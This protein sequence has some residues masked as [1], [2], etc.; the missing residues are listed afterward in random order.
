MRKLFALLNPRERRSF[1]VLVVIMACEAL[2]EMAGIA[3]IP[4]YIT[5]LAFPAGLASQSW[6]SEWLPV[7]WSVVFARENFLVEAGLGV[8]V[9][10]AAKSAYTLAAAYWKGRFVQNRARKL[11][12]RLFAAYLNAPYVF[13]LRTNTAELLRNINHDC[14]QLAA[15]VLMPMVEFIANALILGGILLVML[16]VLEPGVL[17][18]LALFLAAGIGSTTLLQ[19]RVKRLGIQAQEQRGRIIRTVNEGLGGVKEIQVLGRGEHFTARLGRV[20]DEQYH[21]AQQQQLIARSIPT[22]IELTAVAGLVGVTLMLLH[23]GRDTSYIIATLS[24]F[25]VA[26]TR[27]KG[28]V[29]GLMDTY[30]EV[31]HYVPSLNVVYEGL[32]ALE[33]PSSAG[34]DSA[35]D[36]TAGITLERLA[37]RYPGADRDSLVEIDLHIRRG[38][39]IGFVGSTGSGKSTLID[40]VL[41]V[42][43]PSAGRVLIDDRDLRDAVRAWQARVG[44]VPQLLYLVDGTVAENI[45]LGLDRTEVDRARVEEAA[46]A[47]ALMPFVERLPQGLDTVVGERGIRLSGG[48]RQRIVIARALYHRPDVLIM[49][50]ATSALDNTT[51]AA[52]IEAVGRLKGDRTILMVAHRLSTVRR[53]D[54][55]VFLRHGRIDAVGTFDELARDHAEFRRMSQA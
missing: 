55:L 19:N 34:G 38:E 6:L 5:A 41:G 37:Y 9:F 21:V 3:I 27:M 25:A 26:L 36:F 52:V 43:E 22:L 17:F 7:G 51:E 49:D 48:E 40:L 33:G 45:A 8:L 1:F 13:H 32:Q 53:C 2:L 50:E 39:A 46:H 44:Y 42:L 54:R 47:A 12:L 15:R 30:T 31:G 16:A 28:A 18:W 11:S 4:L 35:V 29:R 24:T 14:G 10:F 20:F 23:G